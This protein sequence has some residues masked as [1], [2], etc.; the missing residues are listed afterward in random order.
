MFLLFLQMARLYAYHVDVMQC[1][2]RRI[3]ISI[4]FHNG[5]WSKA[6]THFRS[7]IR[8]VR[9]WQL[10]SFCVCPTLWRLLW[11][12]LLFYSHDEVFS[13]NLTHK[14]NKVFWGSS[15]MEIDNLLDSNLFC[16]KLIIGNILA[17]QFV[18]SDLNVYISGKVTHFNTS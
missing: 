16:F 18:E 12:V 10:L 6:R 11:L 9:D 7:K 14:N 13:H 15:L 2:T 17:A 3:A 8:V 5:S 4:S 1:I